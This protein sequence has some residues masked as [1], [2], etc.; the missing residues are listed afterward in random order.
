VEK[1]RGKEE[2]IKALDRILII[3]FKDYIPV[4]DL[5]FHEYVNGFVELSSFT[6]SPFNQT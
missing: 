6:H 5:Q 3:I 1:R 2:K 4:T